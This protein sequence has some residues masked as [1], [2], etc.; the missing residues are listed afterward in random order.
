MKLHLPSGIKWS[1]LL[2]ATA[3]C[4]AAGA[5]VLVTR[6]VPLLSDLLRPSA[7]IA[8]VD[9]TTPLLAQHEET[10]SL[11]EKRFEGRSLFFA[12]PDWKRKLPPAPPP[13]PP[14][15]PPPPPPPPVDYTGPKVVGMLGNTVYFEGGRSGEVGKETEGVT[16][17][18]VVSPWELKVKH[19]GKEYAVVVGLKPNESVFQPLTTASTPSG[20]TVTPATGGGSSTPAQDAA[21]GKSDPL[22]RLAP[23]PGAGTGSGSSAAGTGAAVG[24]TAAAGS[25]PQ[26]GAAAGAALDAAPAAPVPPIPTPLTARAV[27]QMNVEAARKALSTVAAARGRGDLSATDQQRLEHEEQMLTAKLEELTR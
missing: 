23:A 27:A 1:G 10:H 20:V 22:S 25:A 26:A 19:K 16:V 3:V 15:P 21:A 17:L 7:D 24:A 2:V 12:P 8:A 14:A 6:A 18:E 9:V 5:V 11:Y 13:P 4:S